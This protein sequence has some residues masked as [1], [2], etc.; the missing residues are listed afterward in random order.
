MAARPPGGERSRN[1]GGLLLDLEDSNPVYNDGR[2]PPVTDEELLHQYSIDNFERPQPR[3][4]VSY[5]EFI[6]TQRSA[7]GLP[8][9]PGVPTAG[10]T[11]PP[12]LSVEGGR[13]YSQTSDL[14]NYQRYSDMDDLPDD[15]R[16]MQGGYYHADNAVEGGSSRMV[17]GKGHRS[18]NSVLSMGGGFMGKAKNM[19]G[20]GPEYS[21]MDM[22]LRETA[23]GQQR[24][25]SDMTDEQI[26]RPEHKNLD[27]GNF[28]FGL[29]RGKPDPSTL[30]PRII[31]L[32]NPPANSQNRYLDNHVST[33]KYNIATFLPKFLFE[34]FSKY[35]N[36]FFLFTAAL[37]QI[38]NISPT[39]RYTT[40]GP[41]IIVLLVSAGKELIE[42]FKRKNSDKS[43]NHSKA[44]VLRGSNFDNV[45]W[46]GV[47]VGDIVRV[48]SEEPFPAD[49]VLLASSEPEGLCYIETANLDGETNLKIKQAIPETANLVSPSDLGRLSGRVRSEQ[50]NSSLY[51][52][53]ATLT[54][55]AGGG[56]KELPLAPD[57]LLLRGA[58]LRNTP[59]IHG[60][61]VFTGHETKLMR[62]ATA[63]PIKRTHVERLVNIQILMLV[64]IL[65][66]L[67]VVSSVGDLIVRATAHSKLEYLY[68]EDSGV[69]KQFFSDIFTYWVLYS[70]LVPISLFVTIEVVKYFQALL[71]NSDLDIYYDRTDT[72]AICRT[73]SLVEELGQIE[74]IFSDKTGTLTCNM[75]EFRQ[76]SIGGVQYADDV[77]E[78]RRATEQNAVGVYDFRKLRENLRE[79]QSKTTIHHF[80]ALLATCHTVIPERRDEK[81]GEIK[82]Q[83]AS[84]D[85]GA[86]VEGAVTLGYRFTARRPRSVMITVDGEDYEYELLAVLEF[87]ST[88][89]RMSTIF[90]CP[91]GKVRCYC[92]GADTVILERLSKENPNVEATLQH[93]E[94]YATEGLRTLCLA[95]REIPEQE[96][97]EWLQV[98]DKAN[99]TVSGNR[100]EELDKAAEIIE[101]DFFLLGATAIEDKL[102]DGVPD[103]IHTLQEAGIKI[104]VLTGD[105]Q[106]TAINIGMSCKLISEDMTLLIV[107]EESSN[108]T[109][110]NLENKLSAIRN[111][112][113]G[114]AELETL[115]LVIDGKSLTF[116]LEKGM[117]KT[118]LELAIM[119]K[120]VI[121]WYV[122]PKN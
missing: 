33:A 20:I 117:E 96:L 54:M 58:T 4:S 103:T 98:F 41:L 51:T 8:G 28:K 45:R 101:H 83:A 52:Y 68:I 11:R 19:L 122:N 67:S 75:M 95:M 44:R 2:P 57:Q 104:W 13:T 46:V 43:L 78:D 62:N 61:V 47:K 48:E 93:L 18:R 63:T 40:I 105:R 32:N 9:G 3:P 26:K 112:S 27:I 22:P 107:N 15:D 55:T 118:F 82:Y 80:L 70:N 5:D 86:L 17:S 29:R 79:H 108:A 60:I 109:K 74:Y 71:I 53:E 89:K 100:A 38:P 34:Q 6:G 36:L 23:P 30:G 69:A 42:D 113:A 24:M 94:E 88:R 64:A 12:Y 16:S 56:E 21:E 90:R 7:Q 14:N 35:A 72:P 25:N 119:C 39:N 85:E 81:P 59:W 73:S 37:Q 84:P 115:A 87:N 99:T 91:D 120:A 66:A 121:C 116:A 97:Q 31:H 10:Q 102:Q 49:L 114:G 92:K 110:T 106:E 65:V 76:C 111:Q 77:P 50:P 1:Q